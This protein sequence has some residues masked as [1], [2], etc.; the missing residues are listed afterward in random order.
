[1]SYL[2][3]GHWQSS[4]PIK[5]VRGDLRWLSCSKPSFCVA[6][7]VYGD[8]F[9][10]SGGVWSPPRPLGLSAPNVSCMA[11]ESCLAVDGM[12]QS[13]YFD[14]RGWERLGV[15]EPRVPLWAVS[16]A[17][18]SSCVAVGGDNLAFDWRA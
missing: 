13:A 9:M 16:C 10:Y 2:R 8:A 17:F 7:D 3:E 4:S 18:P 6:M 5:G 1:V 11:V 15:V 14:G 12:G